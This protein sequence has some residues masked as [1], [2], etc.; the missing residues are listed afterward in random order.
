MNT[1]EY[2]ELNQTA[3]KVVKHQEN[4]IEEL[5]Q[6]HPTMSTDERLACKAV[7]S[8]GNMFMQ[9]LVANSTPP[10]RITLFAYKFRSKR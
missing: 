7:K 2:A 1:V 4:Q 3:R 8:K 6:Q 10:P 5:I 9:L